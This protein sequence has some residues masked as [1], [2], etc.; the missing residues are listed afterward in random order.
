MRT[1]TLKLVRELLGMKTQALAI[2]AVVACAVATFVAS[3]G[4]LAAIREARDDAYARYH[5]ADVFAR[6]KRAP[7]AAP[8]ESPRDPRRRPGRGPGGR[9]GR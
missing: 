6:C 8:A 2:A 7:H 4:A 1:L 5:L 9:R 3:L